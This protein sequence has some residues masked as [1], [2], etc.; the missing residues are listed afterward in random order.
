MKEI[1]LAGDT[2]RL[3]AELTFVPGIWSQFSAFSVWLD[4]NLVSRSGLICFFCLVWWQSG[5]KKWFDLIFLFSLP[6]GFWKGCD[7]IVLFGLVPIWFLEGVCFDLSVALVTIWFLEVV[8]FDF[9]DWFGDNLVSRSGLMWFFW[10]V[11]HLVSR[12]GLTRFFWFV[13]HLVSRS[14]LTRF[15]CLVWWHS[16]L[17]LVWFDFSVALVTIWFLE[18]VWFDFSV[19]F[20][21]N[22]VSRSDVISFFWLV[23]WQSGFLKWFDVIFLFGLPFGFKKWFDAIFLLSLPFGFW[24]GFDLIFLFGLVTFGS[25]SGL[26]WFF[27]L[28]WWQAGS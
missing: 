15:F 2:N 7:L 1:L 23:W 25:R 8:W 14:G 3:V 6:F 11:C 4:D 22:L 28:V 26:I 9:S 10:L 21:D 12:S 5:F 16:V 27:C 20:G 24:K 17:E 13:F 18:V 19:W